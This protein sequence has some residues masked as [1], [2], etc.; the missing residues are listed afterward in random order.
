[1]LLVSAAE[2]RELDKMAQ[3][4]GIPALILMENAG[5]ALAD[6]AES[7]LAGMSPGALEDVW[8]AAVRER[9]GQGIPAQGCPRPRTPVQAKDIVVLAGPGQN[10]GDGFCAAR[11]LAAR[12]HKMRVGFFGVEDRLPEEARLNYKALASYPVEIYSCESLSPYE[13]LDALGEPDL[14]IDALLGIGC[15]GDPRFPMD[16]A[17][18]WANSQDA[19]VIACDL[20][21]GVSA[22]SGHAYSPSIRA[23]LTVTMGFA[24]VGLVSYPGRMYTGHLIVESLS[25]SPDLVVDQAGE[26]G[27][28]SAA[29]LQEATPGAGATQAGMR[30][31]AKAA[32]FEEA[33]SLLPERR[34][35]HHKGLS[36]HVLVIAGSVGMAGAAVLAAKGALR[37]GAGTVAVIC[38]GEAYNVCASM[39]P[40]IMVVPCGSS[41][42]FHP[43]QECVDT[44]AD[45]LDRADAVVIGPG[46][47]R[48][49]F[50]TGFLKEI[51]PAVSKKICVADADALFALKQLGGLSYLARIQG[52]FILTPHPG[53]MSVLTGARVEEIEKDRPGWA[54]EAARQGNCIVCLKGAGTCTAGPPGSLVVN[55]SGGPYMATA[56]SGDVLTG[57][58]AALAAQG[59]PSYSSAWL[60]VFW[61]GLAGEVAMKRKGAY[62]I[63][64]GDIIECLPEARA[65]IETQS[66]R[67]Q[68]QGKGRL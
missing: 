68:K 56:G 47:G 50:Q 21:S 29:H 10:G 67:F 60:G 53:E 2:M 24:K 42:V 59:L 26:I 22:D 32:T 18:R 65:L 14:I 6:H 54:R 66:Y 38:P 62:G 39:A 57:V 49:D 37:S 48:G 34:G 20:P 51:L 12:G 13:I 64:A 40:E 58:I 15:K 9:P 11:H 1:M 45:K 33:G 25:F 28:G 46:W 5:R 16:M 43:G 7:L 63:L 3:R 4:R 52:S 19:P 31:L 61:H 55:T 8:S 36:G 30:I 17:I 23:D 44:V 35:N 27:S 41:G